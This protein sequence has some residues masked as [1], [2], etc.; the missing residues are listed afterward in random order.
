MMVVWFLWYWWKLSDSGYIWKV[1]STEFAD[2]LDLDVKETKVK[3][4]KSF[5][6]EELESGTLQE[7]GWF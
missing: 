6:S 4:H 7:A 5:R 2:G 3:D 1:K